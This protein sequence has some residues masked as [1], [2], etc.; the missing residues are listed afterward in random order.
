L[1]PQTARSLIRAIRYGRWTP[2]LVLPFVAMALSQGGD[3]Q[4]DNF[5]WRY[6]QFLAGPEMIEQMKK[7][8]GP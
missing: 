2:L 7:Q 1:T 4:S 8:P 5:D 6:P 3:M